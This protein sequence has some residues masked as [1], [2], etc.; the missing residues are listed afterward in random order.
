MLEA[1]ACWHFPGQTG[2]EGGINASGGCVAG[3]KAALSHLRPGP[4]A[5][6][7][8]GTEAAQACSSQTLSTKLR[9][10]LLRLG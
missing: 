9:S 5:K 3:L 6:R 8:V 4:L 1:L 2:R 7:Q 10:R